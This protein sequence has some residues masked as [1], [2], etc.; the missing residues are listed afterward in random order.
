MEVK[1]KF[2]I[3][4]IKIIKNKL[5]SSAYSLICR[6]DDDDDIDGFK[7]F[8]FNDDV[9]FDKYDHKMNASCHFICCFYISCIYLFICVIYWIYL[10]YHQM[11][12]MSESLPG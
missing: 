10:I 3:K 9:I 12:K 2:F 7:S 4:Y 11:S 5:K 6:D 1:I 8:N